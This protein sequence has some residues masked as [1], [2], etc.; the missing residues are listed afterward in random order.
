MSPD[1]LA[2]LGQELG[3]LSR[4]SLPLDRG[5]AALAQEMRGDKI[6][7]LCENLAQDLGNGIPLDQ[8]LAKH[9]PNMPAHLV[10]LV[11]A[12]LASGRLPQCL[13]RLAGHARMIQQM[14]QGFLQTAFY[15]MVVGLFALALMA[16]L[17]G[18]VIPRF[19]EIYRDFHMPMPILTQGLLTLSLWPW[20][21][22]AILLA[23]IV[24]VP[25]A[26]WFFLGKSGRTKLALRLPVVGG[27]LRE[28][29]M[30]TWYD[31]VAMLLQSGMNLPES[32]RLASEASMDPA[33]AETG[34]LLAQDLA[35]GGAL[36]DGIRKRKL[37]SA[38][39]AWLAEVGQAK[40]V[41]PEHLVELSETSKAQAENRG[42]WLRLVLPPLILLV[43]ALVVV[44]GTVMLLF[45]PMFQ[46][47]D[48]LSS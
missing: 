5:L 8:A 30:A 14:R 7:K 24:V 13:D 19:A 9:D 28:A 35:A 34:K 25:V 2:A 39:G 26:F 36:G 12:G 22:W 17:L 20:T 43:L 10:A 29:S 3:A 42:R 48:R 23:V 45:L 6:G 4:T 27:M 44:G 41:L 32:V 11:K 1:Q 33:L 15:P 31:L 18:F 37:G 47:L 21:R 16:F 38:W 40:G 46:L